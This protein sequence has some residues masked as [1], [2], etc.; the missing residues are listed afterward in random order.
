M[1]VGV[2]AWNKAPRALDVWPMTACRFDLAAHDVEPAPAIVIVA[3]VA[4]LA[5]VRVFAEFFPLMPVAQ[6]IAQR[7]GPGALNAR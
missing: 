1:C 5:K 3:V 4:N 2:S 6:T 7:T